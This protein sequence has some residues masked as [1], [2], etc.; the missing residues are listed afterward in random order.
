MKNVNQPLLYPK[1]SIVT[2]EKRID[3][4]DM[5]LVNNDYYKKLTTNRND[6][7]SNIPDEED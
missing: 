2:W 5:P 6:E 1:G 4:F 7:F 3:I